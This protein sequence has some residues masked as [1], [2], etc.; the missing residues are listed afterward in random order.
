MKTVK[1]VFLDVAERAFIDGI[2]RDP[3]IC[4]ESD[5]PGWFYQN[6]LSDEEKECLKNL[7]A[8]DIQ[9]PLQKML[10]F[11]QPERRRYR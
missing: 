3:F 8:E 9:S 2:I 10:H 5:K 11:G 6:K 7:K 4:R 1:Q